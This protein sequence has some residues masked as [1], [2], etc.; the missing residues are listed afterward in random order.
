MSKYDVIILGSGLGGLTTGATLSKEGYNVCVLEKNPLPGGCFQS[1]KRSGCMLDTGIHYIGSMDEGR[2]L[3]QYFDYY[4][5]TNRLK[6]RRMDEDAFDWVRY[7]GQVYPYAMGHAHFADTLSDLFPGEREAILQYTEMLEATGRSIGREQ[8]EM[9]RFSSGN[10]DNFSVSAWQYICSLTT[11]TTLRQVLSGT[12]LL[13]GGSQEVSTLYQ[14]AMINNSYLE[15]AYRFVDGSMQVANTLVEVIRQQGGTVLTRA[16]AT[17]IVLSG[18]EVKAVEINHGEQLEARYVI[19]SLHPSATLQLVDKTPLIR[20]ANLSRLQLLPNSYGFFSVYLLQKPRTTPYVNSNVY[21][22]AEDNVW[23]CARLSGD[24]KIRSCLLSMQ[25][26]GETPDY[27][28]V[29][30]L[31]CPM[32]MSELRSWEQTV[33]GQRTPGYEAFKQQKAEEL[34]AFAQSHEPGLSLHT[35]KIYTSTPLSFRDY[36]GTPDGSAYGIVKDY[37]NPLTTLIPTRTR[38]PNLYLTGQNLNV[39]GALGVAMT[40]ML[41]CS[42]LLGTEYLAKKV[43]EA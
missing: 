19:S 3:R 2:I 15:G 32:D 16:K 18:D 38:I 8:L 43:K 37:K 4:G 31:L 23:D 28:D 1:Y 11:N 13:Y 22:Y 40:S 12:H 17:R 33:V 26:S 41:T 21:M 9:N 25:A 35:E 24:N 14:H 29:V 36:T 20:K 39:H 10:L 34:I 27:T 7:Q 30:N 5:I 42:E 6:M